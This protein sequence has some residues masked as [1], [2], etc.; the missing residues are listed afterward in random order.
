LFAG[1]ALAAGRAGGYLSGGGVPGLLEGRRAGRWRA[2]GSWRRL[3][4]FSRESRGCGWGREVVSACLR[5]SRGS[6]GVR[7]GPCGCGAGKRREVALP[8]LVGRPWPGMSL[9]VARSSSSEPRRVRA[10][11]AWNLASQCISAG[12][13]HVLG[14]SERAVKTANA[15]PGARN[16]EARSGPPA[17]A[18]TAG[19]RVP[20]PAGGPRRAGRA[21]TRLRCQDGASTC[22]IDSK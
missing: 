9:S 8:L 21:A 15:R 11:T 14:R 19:R 12:Q 7:P 5:R 22:P 2:C 6:G 4:G 16:R 17:A 13:R 20:G 18:R 10:P 1:R 3:A